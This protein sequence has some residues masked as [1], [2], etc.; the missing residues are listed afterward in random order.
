MRAKEKREKMSF[1]WA[2]MAQEKVADGGSRCLNAAARWWIPTHERERGPAGGVVGACSGS[3][4]SGGCL[5]N[6]A[7][8]WMPTHTREKGAAGRVVVLTLRE[9][10]GVLSGLMLA[11]G[12]WAWA[13]L[14]EG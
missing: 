13:S 5:N 8:W 7:C 1:P 9:R 12:C 4:G 6:V 10:G 11:V 14:G 2:L 3:E